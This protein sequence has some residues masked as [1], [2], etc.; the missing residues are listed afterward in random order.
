MLSAASSSNP[1]ASNDEKL[2]SLNAREFPAGDPKCAGNVEAAATAAGLSLATWRAGGVAPEEGIRGRAC[3][4]KPP[5]AH[6]AIT[7]QEGRI[8]R[9]STTRRYASCSRAGGGGVGV[10]TYQWQCRRCDGGRRNRVG[11]VQLGS[12]NGRGKDLHRHTAAHHFPQCD[13]DEGRWRR[14]EWK[15]SMRAGSRNRRHTA[16]TVAGG[17]SRDDGTSTTV[18][19]ANS[20][21]RMLSIADRMRVVSMRRICG[22]YAN[23]ARCIAID[24]AYTRPFAAH[25]SPRA[26]SCS[27]AQPRT[28]SRRACT[29][30]VWASTT[31]ACR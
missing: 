16:H 30:N 19:T 3:E 12:C 18:L 17:H 23:A 13:C 5:C 20:G 14:H 31:T 25:L 26:P 24:G 1:D 21:R 22:R 7:V 15:A 11:C 2:A 8:K 10:G 27:H 6:H 4:A 9:Q 28:E 29:S